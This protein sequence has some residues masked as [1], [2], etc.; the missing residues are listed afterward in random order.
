MKKLSVFA[1]TLVVAFAAIAAKIS[2][3]PTPAAANSDVLS[4]LPDGQA[5]IVI[6]VQGVLRS[7][8]FSIEKLKNLLDKAQ[9]EVTKAGFNLSDINTAAISF[10][11]S[12]FNNPTVVVTGNFNQTQLLAHLREDSKVKVETAKYK[13]I[14]VYTATNVAP[15]KG[16]TSDPLS[17]AFYDANTIVAGNV[18]GVRASID[19]RNGEKPSINSNSKLMGGLSQN[20]TA[21]IRFAFSVNPEMT[22]KF[23]S[24][25]IPMPSFDSV[26]LVFGYVEM[27][28][29]VDLNLTARNDTAEHA[30]NIADQLNSLLSMVKGFLGAS[31]DPKMAGIVAA[32]KSVTIANTDI[33]VKI[34]ASVPIELLS[35]FIK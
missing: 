22:K 27:S 11:G 24:E 25:Q 15:V 14:D 34:T 12:Q 19:T 32:I 28:K 1:L 9:G 29:G 5:V 10:S 21:P 6:D 4:L 13:G 17:L 26:N 8:L 30:K 3:R 20:T 7:N 16:K 31:D 2:V 23:S 35:Q 18:A 33:D